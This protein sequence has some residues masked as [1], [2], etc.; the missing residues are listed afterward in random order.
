MQKCPECVTLIFCK[1]V[2]YS[3]QYFQEVILLPQV[4]MK[5][6]FFDIL[7]KACSQFICKQLLQL[8]IRQG[9]IVSTVI[10]FRRNHLSKGDRCSIVYTAYALNA[11]I[12]QWSVLRSCF[13]GYLASHFQ[14]V[15]DRRWNWWNQHRQGG[16]RGR[17]RDRRR[18]SRTLRRTADALVRRGWRWAPSE[19]GLPDRSWWLMWGSCRFLRSHLEMARILIDSGVE[20][21]VSRAPADLWRTG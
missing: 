5:S 18:W 10:D 8:L 16:R 21:Y 17:I 1:E 6:Y 14:H 11:M 20:V 9:S 4:L 2:V 7:L 15:C 12:R 19:P 3:S 13:S